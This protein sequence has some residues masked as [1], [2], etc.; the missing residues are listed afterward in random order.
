MTFDHQDEPLSQWKATEST[1]AKLSNNR[2]T[3]RIWVRCAETDVGQRPGLTT[4]ERTRMKDRPVHAE[5]L[6]VYGADKM[7]A[8]LNREGDPDPCQGPASITRQP[9]AV[10]ERR[11]ISTLHFRISSVRSVAFGLTSEAP[12]A[13][14]GA[15]SGG[16]QAGM[17]DCQ[18]TRGGTVTVRALSRRLVFA[19]LVGGALIMTGCSSSP[20]AAPG[21]STSLA[22]PTSVAAPG[23]SI[24]FNLADNALAHVSTRPC[25]RTPTG[26]VLDGVVRNPA[27]V[28]KKFQ[29]VVDF[30]SQIG[31]TV[32]AT[33]VLNVPLLAPGGTATWAAIGAK[34][35][36]GVNCVVRLAQSR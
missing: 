1:S 32:L 31:S 25:R 30:V 21:A 33:T 29:I 12:H 5:N 10:E 22:Q 27:K 20:S 8:Q 3:P 15:S 23:A 16:V 35:K 11:E 4:G 26:W 6:A 13:I 18:S 2:E 24:P 17:L 36:S 9:F 14:Q 19:L 34:G 28:E 7:W